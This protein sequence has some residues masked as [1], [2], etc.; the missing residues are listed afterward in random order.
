MAVFNSFQEPEETQSPRDNW[1][2]RARKRNEPVRDF[3]V[4]D[5]VSDNGV[6]GFKKILEDA[7]AVVKKVRRWYLE[8]FH[9]HIEDNKTFY[10]KKGENVPLFMHSRDSNEILIAKDHLSDD[11][12]EAMVLL[13]KDEFGDGQIEIF[14]G[15][16]FI[17]RVKEVIAMK[18]ID[19][20]ISDGKNTQK[21]RQ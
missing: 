13:A 8:A 4:N 16:D 21:L 17:A 18:N 2:T 6:R 1:Q 10:M 19:V 11:V 5:F 7:D 15:E 20:N 12:I 3:N 9:E 14:G